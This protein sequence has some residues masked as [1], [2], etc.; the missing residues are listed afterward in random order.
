ME[1]IS[2]V[3]KENHSHNKMSGRYPHTPFT[4]AARPIF[5]ITFRRRPSFLKATTN[6]AAWKGSWWYERGDSGGNWRGKRMNDKRMGLKEKRK[7]EECYPE[8]K[9]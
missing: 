5:L 8:V 3:G 9:T 6:Q 2:L 1:A 7:V 4:D